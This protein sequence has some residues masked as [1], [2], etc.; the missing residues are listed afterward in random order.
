VSYKKWREFLAEV[1]RMQ[2]VLD[3]IIEQA[4]NLTTE[5]Q[6]KLVLC[7]QSFWRLSESFVQTLVCCARE[8]R[9]EAA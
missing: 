4:A 8:A 2:A 5:E 7:N 1:K 6:Q 9:R 3:E